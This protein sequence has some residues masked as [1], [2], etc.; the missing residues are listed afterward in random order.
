VASSPPQLAAIRG[1]AAAASTR[2]DRAFIRISAS[3]PSAARILPCQPRPSEERLR[4]AHRHWRSSRA[5][6]SFRIVP[7]LQSQT[8]AI[9]GHEIR[10]FRAGQGPV[11]LLIHGMACS[12]TSWKAIVPR[13][14]ERYTVIA[15]DLLGHGRSAKPRTDYSLG[16]YASSLRDLLVALGIERATLVGQSLGGGIAMQMAYQYPERAERLVLVGSGG[17]GREVNAVLRLLTV[18]GAEYVMPLFFPTF[19]RD[20]G[21]RMS[22]GL[23]R[24]GLRAPAIAEIWRAYVS[25]TDAESRASFVRTLRAVIDPGGQ[26]VSA[27]DRLYLAANMPTLIVWGARDPVIPVEHAH[28]AQQAMPGSRL[29]IFDESG[30]FPHIEEADRFIEVLTDFLG[31]TAAAELDERTWQRLLTKNV[32]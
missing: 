18:P 9:H 7:A 16:A 24:V 31:T 22:L 10:F 4:R 14:S 13:L 6:A 21:N 17:L 11:L 20:F 32:A 12:A 25:L 15:P 8:I 28:A 23:H 19:V 1:A 3:S 30:H 26:S 29:E 2:R 27:H 5:G